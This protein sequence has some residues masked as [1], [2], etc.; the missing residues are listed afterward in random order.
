MDAKYAKYKKD[1]LKYFGAKVVIDKELEAIKLRRGQKY[2]PKR[3][4][5]LSGGGIRSACFALGVLQALSF[6][7][8]LEKIDYLSTVSGGGYI[9]SC[10][11][12][13]LH[14]AW[15]SSNGRVWFGTGWDSFPLG[16]YPMANPEGGTTETQQEPPRFRGSILRFLREQA[17]YL[18][19]AQGGITM[20]SLI[21]VV[22]A[23]VMLS[24]AFFLTLAI[25]VF[26]CLR[27]AFGVSKT[28]M[29]PNWQLLAIVIA[30]PLICRLA[31]LLITCL[32]HSFK[33][34]RQHRA[35]HKT[36]IKQR[37]LQKC[38]QNMV[39]WVLKITMVLSAI[40][41]IW[42]TVPCLL[43]SVTHINS[44]IADFY[45]QLYPW[46]SNPLLGMAYLLCMLYLVFAVLYGFGT[47]FFQFINYFENHEANPYRWRQFIER[48]FNF[49]LLG[50][51]GFGLL[52]LVFVDFSL[53]LE[54]RSNWGVNLFYSG[55]NYTDMALCFTA[56]GLLLIAAAFLQTGTSNGHKLSTDKLANMGGLLLLFGFLY[57]SN[58]L[59]QR[60]EGHV[61][62]GLWF[63]V[64]VALGWLVDLNY[65]SFH[66]YYR[67]R[68]METF[69]PNIEELLADSKLIGET[70]GNRFT[71]QQMWGGKQ[72]NFR[73]KSADG[74][75]TDWMV[76]YHIIN[77]NVVLVDSDI[78]KYRGRKGDNFI[79]SPLYCGSN[80]T[81][82][83]AS[84]SRWYKGFSVATA[85]GIS[86][87]ALNPNAAENGEGVT[88]GRVLSM[89]MGLLNIRLGFWV[90]NPQWAADS[91]H[92]KKVFNG[93]KRLLAWLSELGVDK[94]MT[95]N[96][97]YPGFGEVVMRSNL[98]ENS[99]WLQLS[100]GGHFENLGLYELVR[101]RLELIIVSDGGADPDYKFTDL[102]NAIEKVRVDFGALITFADGALESLI[103][104]SDPN[105]AGLKAD[106][107]EPMRYAKCGYIIGNICYA[108]NSKGKIVY[109][110]T[111]FTKSL[112]A[113]LYG[114]RRSHP[115]FPDV[116]TSNQ[117]FNEKQF[118]AYRELG[119][120]TA[121]QM[122]NDHKLVTMWY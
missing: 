1:D 48:L 105:A 42:M 62:L 100:D 9:G 54:D 32:C 8:R 72:D 23:N 59:A 94:E 68:L 69:L 67:D 81:G 31:S 61:P 92:I 108:D 28:T 79:F 29:V 14:T 13:L 78:S 114:Y 74:S 80:A 56:I 43:V 120:Q 111:T 25:L 122:L 64:A 15:S 38:V 98:D 75:S 58:Y 82:W 110:P 104:V 71:L 99:G 91:K 47:W 55:F 17:K 35:P 49:T 19:S 57:F 63:F 11:S 7:G 121:F 101:R 109:L 18:E 83:A 95:P 118:E 107:G 16:S 115:E 73:R 65:I 87:A 45:G 93:F 117:F 30:L 2:D 5:A 21:G 86:G 113:D 4:L 37:T 44:I 27:Y 3:G 39:L 33:T 84:D 6:K 119:F 76:P 90:P 53:M 66:R 36:P 51:F 116:P 106:G 85:M 50:M 46:L 77:A 40:V 12:Y 96:F 24:I 112:G 41:L 70:T 20:L 34:V 26:S 103:P 102:T 89:L 97:I 10:L 22:L 52:G 88:H 60:G